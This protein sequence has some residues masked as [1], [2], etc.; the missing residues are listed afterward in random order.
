MKYTLF[1]YLLVFSCYLSAQV[2]NDECQNAE[3]L[4]LLPFCEQTIFTNV[5]ATTS[6]IGDRNTPE[7]FG[8]SSPSQDIWFTFSIPDNLTDI[9]IVL[10]GSENGSEGQPI[11][12]PQIA[13]YRGSCD[14]NQLL[15]IGCNA[16]SDGGTALRLDA[17]GLTPDIP[18]FVR[19]N[20]NI[21]DNSN[22]D[23]DFTLCIEAFEPFL[24]IG[25]VERTTACS[26]R[27]FDSGGPAGNY[28]NNENQLLT[29]C[30]E[31]DHSCIVV[32]LESFTIDEFD[33]LNIYAG[34]DNTGDLLSRV[35]GSSLGTSFTVES[36]TSCITLEFKSDN[37]ATFAGFALS[38]SCRENDCTGETLDAQST[39][40]SV[41]FQGSFSTC[42]AASNFVN[43]PCNTASFLNGPEL[44]M[45]YDSPGGFCTAI[46]ISN[47]EPGTGVVVLDGPPNQATS[48]CVAQSQSGMLNSVDTRIPGT[49]YIIVA[50][51]QGC[52]DFDIDIQEAD[53]QL[54]PALKDALCTPINNCLDGP[55]EPFTIF[56]E[57]G[58]KD[59]DIKTGVN[60][61]CWL[62]DG[63]EPDY[64]WFS[65]QAAEDGDFGFILESNGVPSDIDFNVWGPFTEEQTCGN[66]NEVT[67]FI[68]QNQPIRSSWHNEAVPTGL[69]RV[70][71]VNGNPI[72][73]LY[74]C[75]GTP[76]GEGDG[77][78]L[79]IEMK[80]GEILF[81]T[82]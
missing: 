70:H 55:N 1:L 69:A 16:E 36:N 38:W 74:D 29:I 22:F 17:L 37:T 67:Q 79:P 76:S 11:I 15:E 32:E 14:F 51:G 61:G 18:Y 30:P 53:C 50:N 42:G 28:K 44:V 2:G 25:D 27:V 54:S 58:F 33:Q 19:V 43:T 75:G 52:T 31:T 20:S 82:H 59:A 78:V 72:E 24:N 66:P 63:A 13:L 48:T 40:P 10:Q 35:Q 56:L 7:C 46:S 6:N 45:T 12:N 9:T 8:T 60:A 3:N 77:F 57:N 49:Y 64:Y 62:S 23:G 65:V 4:G 34:E 73:D 41:P 80:K 5:G 81:S 39:I 21:V 47:A 68:A 26:G 71:P